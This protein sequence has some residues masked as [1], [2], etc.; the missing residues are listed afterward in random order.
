MHYSALFAAALSAPLLAGALPLDAKR[1]PQDYANYGT[2]STPT[3][4]SIP[5]GFNAYGVY[6]SYPTPVPTTT[7]SS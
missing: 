1:A 5:S 7:A 4:T 2:Y 6:D 3:T